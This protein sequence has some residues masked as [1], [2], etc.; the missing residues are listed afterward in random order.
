[1]LWLQITDG[2][3]SCRELWD[4]PRAGPDGAAAFTGVDKVG[5]VVTQ[6]FV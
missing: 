3:T 5:S 1:M 6:T 2:I 4:G